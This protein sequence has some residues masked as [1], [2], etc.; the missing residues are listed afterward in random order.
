MTHA[1]PKI[2]GFDNKRHK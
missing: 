2:I 1:S